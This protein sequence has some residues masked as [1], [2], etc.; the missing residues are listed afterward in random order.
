MNE[1]PEFIAFHYLYRDGGS[2]KKRGIL[3]YSNPGKKTLA[4]VETIIRQNLID[5]I[6]FVHSDWNIP[7]LYFENFDWNIDHQ[8]HEFDHLEFAEIKAAQDS[9]ENLIRVMESSAMI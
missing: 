5:E 9:I 1:I 7:D 2:N 8:W 4:E 6:W 3:I